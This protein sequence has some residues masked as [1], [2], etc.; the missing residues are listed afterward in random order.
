LSEGPFR[1]WLKERRLK[2]T[3]KLTKNPLEEALRILPKYYNCPEAK[4]RLVWYFGHNWETLK[5]T[6]LI[7]LEETKD[8]DDAVAW[9]LHELVEAC[10]VYKIAPWLQSPV[11]SIPFPDNFFRDIYPKAH[12][13]ATQIELKFLKDIKREDLIKKVEQRRPLMF[14]QFLIEKRL[15]VPGPEVRR[16]RV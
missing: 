9:E 15:P 5:K 6:S 14:S 12:E 11:L 13:K 4:E 2:Y 16:A 1:R 8:W 7:L 3:Q 10:E